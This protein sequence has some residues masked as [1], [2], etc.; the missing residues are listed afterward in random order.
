MPP[1]ITTFTTLRHFGYAVQPRNAEPVRLWRSFIGEPHSSHVVFSSS[2]AST[3]SSSGSGMFSVNVQLGYPLQATKRPFFPIR[4]FSF[5]PH[6][7]HAS[8]VAGTTG[9][10]SSLRASPSG[11]PALP[12]TISSRARSRSTVNVL[13]NSFSAAR[14]E[15]VP[16]STSSRR[17][18]IRAV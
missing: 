1:A 4:S 12:E 2:D 11:I 8:A 3:A 18:S 9:K 13:S 10:E 6:F 17:S 5:F 14:Q 16:S 15:S 7:G